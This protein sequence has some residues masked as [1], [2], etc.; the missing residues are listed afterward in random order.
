[1]TVFKFFILSLALVLAGCEK[2]PEQTATEK[3]MGGSTETDTQ[4]EVPKSETTMTESETRVEVPESE[5][6]PT[7]DTQ[8][9]SLTMSSGEDAEVPKDFPSD[10]YIYSPSEVVTTMDTPGGSVLG[11]TTADDAAKIA[12]TYQREMVDRGWSEQTTVNNGEQ[13]MLMYKNDERSANITIGSKDGASQI[14]VT[15]TKN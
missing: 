11:L 13:I 6:T 9:E 14:M 3:E 10:V 8:R 7:E 1:M 4:V 12:E 2:A 15:A 5:T